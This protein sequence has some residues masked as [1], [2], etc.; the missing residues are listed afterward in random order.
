MLT[1]WAERKVFRR[2]CRGRPAAGHAGHAATSTGGCQHCRASPAGAA[3][4]VTAIR[5]GAAAGAAAGATCTLRWLWGLCHAWHRPESLLHRS[6]SSPHARRPRCSNSQG[7]LHLRRARQRQATCRGLRLRRTTPACRCR[8]TPASYAPQ[9]QMQPLPGYAYGQP[10]AYGPGQPYPDPALRPVLPAWV[11][12]AAGLCAAAGGQVSSSAQLVSRS[13][14][15]GLAE[16]QL[17]HSSSRCPHLGAAQ[18]LHRP[19]P[20]GVS[21]RAGWLQSLLT[22][23]VPQTPY[24]PYGYAPYPGM[25]PQMPFGAQPGAPGFAPLPMPGL[26]AKGLQPGGVQLNQPALALLL[27]AC[28][29]QPGTP[30]GGGGG[31]GEAQLVH[32]AC[33]T[34]L[35]LHI[36]GRASPVLRRAQGPS[37]GG[38]QL[39][40]RPH[41]APG[42]RQAAHGAALHAPGPPRH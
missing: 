25:M 9:P 40:G 16:Q 11:L 10:G 28:I 37:Q 41:P 14:A 4:S 36:T 8:P 30:G 5:A 34:P 20:A 24:A 1:L 2:A 38:A 27:S 21:G 17:L 29:S 13:L 7:L 31:R 6:D 3:A 42:E 33:G 39:P 22:H 26:P 18:H 23:R 12:P 19:G 35:L 15:A 32:T